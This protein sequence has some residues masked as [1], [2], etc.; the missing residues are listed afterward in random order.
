MI[1][2]SSF[3]GPSLAQSYVSDEVIGLLRAREDGKAV[4][5]LDFGRLKSGQ[6]VQVTEGGLEANFAETNDQTRSWIFISLL[7]KVNRVLMGS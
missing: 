7:G 2:V 4:A 6:R 1:G 3:A 5:Q